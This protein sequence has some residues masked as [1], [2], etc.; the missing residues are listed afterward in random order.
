[1]V[2]SE[3]PQ[4]MVQFCQFASKKA[5]IIVSS[6]ILKNPGHDLTLLPVP[7]VVKISLTIN[8]VWT[9]ICEVTAPEQKNVKI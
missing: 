8:R 3:D 4:G 6:Q 2:Q 7:T 1:M 5:Y 9:G